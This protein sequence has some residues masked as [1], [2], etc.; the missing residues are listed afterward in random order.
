MFPSTNQLTILKL[1]FCYLLVD[2]HTA[3]NVGV[4]EGTPETC[5]YY[6]R[7]CL[8][9]TTFG[10][11]WIEGGPAIFFSAYC[12]VSGKL[13]IIFCS[14]VSEFQQHYKFIWLWGWLLLFCCV[15]G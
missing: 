9:D 7:L 15:D 11:K 10:V 14:C 12:I 6:T 3:K 5:N 8:Y 13:S 2:S 1:M 4:L